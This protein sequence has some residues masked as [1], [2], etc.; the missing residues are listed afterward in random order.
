MASVAITLERSSEAA[1]LVEARPG[2]PCPL[3]LDWRDL[4]AAEVAEWRNLARATSEPN[5]FFEDWYLLPALKAHDTSHEVRLFVLERE[6]RWLGV[7]PV[8]KRNRYY[9]KPIPHLAGWMHANCFLG[10]PLV[11]KGHERAFWQAL[12]RW[13]DRSP[14]RALFLHLAQIPLQGELFGA[15]RQLGRTGGIVQSEERA[16]LASDLTPEA[17]LEASMTGKKRK[18]LRRQANRL[19][20]LGELTFERRDDDEGVEAWAKGFLELEKAGWKGKAGSALAC[21]PATETLFQQALAGG[22]KAGRLERLALYLDGQ[23]IAMLANFLTAPGAFSYKTAFD[24]GFARFSPG[25]LLQRENLTL[26]ERAGIE[27][28]DSCAAADHPMIDHIWR[29]RR[30][31]GAVSIAIGGPLRRA[32]F[33]PLLKA[34]LGR[35]P[36]GARL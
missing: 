23:P 9:G 7:M 8:V 24:E 1:V 3:L 30:A 5:P 13:A 35:R 34:E 19:S 26:L 28:C 33:R 18:E 11:A 22:A 12:L 29:E 25:V 16:L 27:W 14:G 32:F 21:S 10:A 2:E 15:L 31:V 4:G 20:K 36:D 6:G 17:Y